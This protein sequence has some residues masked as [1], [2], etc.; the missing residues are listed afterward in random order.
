MKS[1]SEMGQVE[2]LEDFANLCR[3]HFKKIKLKISNYLNPKF[4]INT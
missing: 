3:F 4:V 2:V 1:P